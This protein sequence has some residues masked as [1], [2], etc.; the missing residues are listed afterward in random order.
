[1]VATGEHIIKQRLATL[2][3]IVA[4][5]LL[6]ACSRPTSR[7]AVVYDP[8]GP[9]MVT[10]AAATHT[11][12]MATRAAQQQI[13]ATATAEA[14]LNQQA[15]RTAEQV[16]ATAA[17][18]ATAV[19][20]VPTATEAARIAAVKAELDNLELQAAR[21][22]ID[23]QAQL[24]LV[25]LRHTEQRM[26]AQVAN[27]QRQ[28]QI[29]AAWSIAKLAMFVL[30]CIVLSGGAMAFLILRYKD[31]RLRAEAL[32]YY[33]SVNPNP[34][35]QNSAPAQITSSRPPS[36]EIRLL[37]GQVA[38]WSMFADWRDTVKVPLGVSPQGPIIINTVYSPHL[39]IAGATGKGKTTG[40]LWP[41]A[42]WALT[43]GQN[44]I[45]LNE[46]AANFSAFYSHPNADHIRA[47]DDQSRVEAAME[48]LDS[49]RREMERRDRMLHAA[50]LDSWASL[51]N[52]EPGESGNVMIVIDEFLTLATLGGTQVHRQMMQAAISLTSQAR[53]F[54]ISLVLVATDPRRDA[55]GQQGYTAIKQCARI[56]FGFH[57]AGSSRSVLGDTSA[58]NLPPGRMIVDDTNGNRHVGL[59]FHPQKDDISTLLRSRPVRPT[60]LPDL[61]RAVSDGETVIEAPEP[62]LPVLS[63]DEQEARAAGVDPQVVAD[64]RLI[65]RYTGSRR[66]RTRRAITERLKDD[67]EIGWGSTGQNIARAE[68]ALLYLR[69]H[70]ANEWAAQILE[71]APTSALAFATD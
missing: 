22:Q 66:I 19:A 12:D 47:Y 34:P 11:A 69:D 3:L 32:D 18:S 54:G 52:V 59:A 1:M 57:D 46:R 44:V 55:L 21:Q 45:F 26:A 61:L 16:T 37:E 13:I 36:D 65:S 7:E 56:A 2:I 42:A 51:R 63:A 50:G 48:T 64:A 58:L 53:K 25:T 43:T 27:E 38:N 70:K 41:L 10:I 33:K 4:L 28:N 15:T 31:H 9:A 68:L 39:F 30:L 60:P 71:E 20:A 67:G 24:D 40:G 17:A 23:A 5:P 62:A 29:D 49:A 35:P 6:V 8:I 14:Y